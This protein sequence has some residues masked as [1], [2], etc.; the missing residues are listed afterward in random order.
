M[1]RSSLR[2]IR[3]VTR[4]ELVALAT[5]RAYLISMVVAAALIIGVFVVTSAFPAQPLRVGLVGAQPE[6]ALEALE[7]AAGEGGVETEALSHEAVGGDADELLSLLTEANLDAVIVD[8]EQILV[9]SQDTGLVRRI[10][11]AW[12]QARVFSEL[13][14]AGV[15]QS[16]LDEAFS[17]LAVQVLEPDSDDR[18]TSQGAGFV[19]VVVVFLSIQFTSAYIM[20]GILQEKGSKIV[21]LLLS[22]VSARDLLVG[23][24]LGIGLLGLV[25]VGVL[26]ASF[27]VGAL[28]SGVDLPTLEPGAVL[29]ALAFVLVGMVF[30]SGLFA[31]G[32]SLAPGIED[33]QATMAPINIVVVLSYFGSFGVSAAPDHWATQALA[34]FPSV[35]PFAF[36]ALVTSGQASVVEAVIALFTTL[37]SAAGV[38]T[39]AA[40]IY[41]RSVV[42][43]D[44]RLG[45][46]E[47]WS[48]EPA[49]TSD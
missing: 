41:V 35:T 6:G 33:A 43:T 11:T 32:A 28:I 37:V 34:Y 48:L 23:K 16:V 44:R 1:N 8:G 27:L 22:T 31:A 49:T 46:R 12:G 24:V 17:P 19:T 47:A 7:A 10:Q 18:E 20:M 38:F 42:H 39:V 13:T 25:Q 3:L 30:Y 40:R 14:A 15:S 29:L 21:E 9:A 2:A 26:I 5:S 45:W 36:P 4:R